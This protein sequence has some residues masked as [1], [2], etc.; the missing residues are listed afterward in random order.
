[1]EELEKFWRDFPGCEAALS[2]DY[3]ERGSLAR[4]QQANLPEYSQA[5][6]LYHTVRLSLR[7]EGIQ[8]VYACIVAD[9]ADN[10]DKIDIYIKWGLIAT[11]RRELSNTFNIR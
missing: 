6:Y 5:N 4:V 10:T 8:F 3:P 9:A 1:M 7:V 11:A 2:C